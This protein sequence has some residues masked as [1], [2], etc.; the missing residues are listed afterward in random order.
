MPIIELPRKEGGGPAG[1]NDPVDEGGGPAGVV[2]G[3]DA[4]KEKGLLPPPVTVIVLLTVASDAVQYVL[5]T[6][7]AGSAVIGF[8]VVATTLMCKTGKLILLSRL[9][10]SP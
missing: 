3:F 5:F 4:P 6:S 7:V 2:E 10:N 1:V 9:P 8:A